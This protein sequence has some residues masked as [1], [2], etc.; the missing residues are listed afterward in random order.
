MADT[1]QSQ[2]PWIYEGLRIHRDGKPFAQFRQAETG[3]TATFGWK[4]RTF[5]GA[6]VGRIYDIDTERKDDDRISVIWPNWRTA[7]SRPL[8][9]EE[10]R[11]ALAMADQASRTSLRAMKA[12]EKMAKEDRLGRELVE[13]RKA[14][15]R[16]RTP[17]QRRAFQLA[18][19]DLL[20][21]SF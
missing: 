13:I 4:E 1:T 17:M 14:Y 3:N 5:S 21:K 15:S 19:L 16:L 18:L 6:L 8:E 2:E 11:T 7:D 20:D 9:D 12:A 10:A